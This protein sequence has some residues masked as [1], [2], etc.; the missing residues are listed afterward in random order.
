MM[1]GGE[2]DLF[3]VCFLNPACFHLSGH[4]NTQDNRHLSPGN[5]RLMHEVPLH[6]I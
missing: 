1:C 3:L 5:P 2:V 6:D 4:V